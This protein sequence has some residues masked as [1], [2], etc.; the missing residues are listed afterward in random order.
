MGN[1]IIMVRIRNETD[2]T[3]KFT[4]KYSRCLGLGSSNWDVKLNESINP[5]NMDYGTIQVPLKY[6]E[7][8]GVEY[9]TPDGTKICVIFGTY[10]ITDRAI[11]G[12]IG[13]S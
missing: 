8:A 7:R 6:N 11:A 5:K 9:T 12:K 4:N 1:T 13:K 3:L 2:E 10:K